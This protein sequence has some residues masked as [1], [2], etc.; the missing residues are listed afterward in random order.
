MDEKK[1]KE[2]IKNSAKDLEIPESLEP[3]NIEKML[4]NVKQNPV[5][6]TARISIYS[7]RLGAAAAAA[8]V[9]GLSYQALELAKSTSEKS[10][11]S[12]RVWATENPGSENLTEQPISGQS[13]NDEE[14]AEGALDGEKEVLATESSLARGAEAGA[15]EEN[16][17]YGAE[18]GA[19]E[20]NRV[21]RTEDIVAGDSPS[22]V[23]KA[24][25]DAVGISPSVK[26]T[27]SKTGFVPASGYEEIFEAIQEWQD[28]NMYNGMYVYY[29]M[30]TADGAERVESAATGGIQK[31]AVAEASAFCE[32]EGAADYSTTNLM[33]MGVDEGDIVKTD[34]EF[35]YILNEN[36]LDILKISGPEAE[37][38]GE[39]TLLDAAQDSFREMYV[40][41]ERVVLIADGVTTLMQENADGEYSMQSRPY[42][43]AY[44]YGLT[45]PKNPKLLGT[46]KVEG[47]YRTSRRNG[48]YLYLMTDYI[49]IIGTSAF[50]STFIPLV[51]GENIAASDVLLPYKME[52]CNSLVAVSVDLSSP[53]KICSQ[54]AL[55]GISNLIYVSRE[56]IYVTQMEWNSGKETTNIMKFSYEN[57]SLKGKAAG[58]VP[59]Y[60]N[61]AFS[62][63]EYEGNLRVVSTDWDEENKNGLYILDDNMQTVGKIENLAPGE[64]IYSARFMGNTGYFVTFRNTDPL[65]SVDLKDPANPR[66]LGE[67]KVTGFSEYLHF[68][69]EDKLLGIG[70]EADAENGIIT[71]VKLSIFD[72]SDPENVTEENR[73]VIDGADLYCP[74]TDNYKAILA[75]AH[76]NIIGL[77]IGNEYLAFTYSK[78]E[79]FQKVLDADLTGRVQ[80]ARGVY[81]KD[82]FYLSDSGTLSIADMANGFGTIKKFAY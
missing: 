62:M 48:N 64:Q 50:D 59:G 15:T 49:P 74:G 67:L 18:E 16:P 27:A 39:I 12:T 3:E 9:L 42:T 51:N 78:E 81:V 29:D 36:K 7:R 47:C 45:D 5:R 73:R 58:S 10:I 77:A 1:W 21:Y 13:E 2:K 75:D 37:I 31:S 65:F 22:R 82:Y 79:G 80:N 44:T 14:Q 38:M 60:L 17:A 30:G 4:Q 32:E 70:R 68:W 53:E 6:R 35:L 34:G 55:V 8:L 56:S 63:N 54:R 23:S 19:I 76:K 41:E 11:S 43:A 57:G 71:G 20:E 61:D 52:S 26:E 72:I 69:G 40:D 33:E 66:I 24:S 46:V 28:E 25:A